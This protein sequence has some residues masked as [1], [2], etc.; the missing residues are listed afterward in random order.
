MPDEAPILSPQQ[1]AALLAL[2]RRA[3]RERVRGVVS[4]S[5]LPTDS[6]LQQPGAAF[7]T[8]TR[9]G[10]LRGCIGFVRAVQ[11]LAETVRHCAVAAATADPRFPPVSGS[12]LP[13]LHLEISVL[14][15][16]RRID[17]VAGIQIG[18][19]GLYISQGSRHG[20]LLPQVAT[21]YGWDR[22]T[23]LSHACLKAGLPGDAWRR[24]AD[25][26]VFTVDHFSDGRPLEET[27]PAASDQLPLKP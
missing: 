21:E 3:I 12:E 8:L 6:A 11:S 4:V 9:D 1:R 24:G 25:I 2:A 27:A 17:S 5:A 26:Q 7:V 23:F 10:A 20:L 15:P 14:S 18:R 13:H 16:L 22:D 19:H